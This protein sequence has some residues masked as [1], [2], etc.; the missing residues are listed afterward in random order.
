[1]IVTVL[2]AS[3]LGELPGLPAADDTALLR[4][5]DRG[6]VPGHVLVLTPAHGLV[7]AR[8]QAHVLVSAHRE[9]KVCVLPLAHHALTLTLIAY[10]LL[11]GPGTDGDPTSVLSPGTL[12]HHLKRLGITAAIDTELD[13]QL[14]IGDEILSRIERE[15][16]DLL[17][18]GAFGRSRMWE[19]LFGGTSRTLLHQMMV[20]VL[21]SH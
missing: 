21:A 18:A 8:E 17:V 7:A 12:V 10:E 2:G 1:M 5:A 11:S 19:R 3:H 16:V 4:L 14:P 9:V 13:M 6:P 15:E 20:P